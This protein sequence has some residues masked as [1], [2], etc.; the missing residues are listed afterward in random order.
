MTV[1]EQE[2]IVKEWRT[3][4]KTMKDWCAENNFRQRTLETYSWHYNKRHGLSKE[5]KKTKEGIVELV[6]VKQKVSNLT[7]E[8][9]NCV[10]N[11][12]EHT[13]LNLLKKVA[14]ALGNA[15]SQ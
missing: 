8:V 4:G 9:G 6:P 2:K 14:A 11:V 7:V 13:D 3:S 12:S 15:G 10:I 1:E 5:R